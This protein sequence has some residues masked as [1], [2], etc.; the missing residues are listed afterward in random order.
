[1]REGTPA[2]VS[3]VLATLAAFAWDYMTPERVNAGTVRALQYRAYSQESTIDRLTGELGIERDKLT[4]IV[5]KLTLAA[6]PV[7]VRS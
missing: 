4:A 5:G 7:T 3:K 2:A 6:R 1:M